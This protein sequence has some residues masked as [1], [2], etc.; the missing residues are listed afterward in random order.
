VTLKH[1]QCATPQEELAR[2]AAEFRRGLRA[3]FGDTLSA[4]DVEDIVQGALITRA[5]TVDDGRNAR[6]RK[7]WFTR[8]VHNLAIDYVR[9]RDGRNRAGRGPRQL[10]LDL[11]DQLYDGQAE[12]VIDALRV[13]EQGFD[14]DDLDRE[15]DTD[16]TRKLVRRAL[17]RLSREERRLIGLRFREGLSNA[18][19]ADTV[20]LTIKGLEKRWARTWV[21]FV[22]EAAGDAV[23]EERC[24]AMRHAAASQHVGI[25]TRDDAARW[26]AHLQECPACRVWHHVGS[27]ASAAIPAL[28]LGGGLLGKLGLVALVER[29]HAAGDQV[30]AAVGVGGGSAGA[31]VLSAIGGKAAATCITALVCA[32]GAA[33][34]A[35]PVV[36]RAVDPPKKE[37]RDEAA[38]KPHA[39]AAGASGAQRPTTTIT[40]APASV[41]PASQVAR[42]A[43]RTQASV[44]TAA[45]QRKTRESARIKREKAQAKQAR[46]TGSPFTP[47]A[48]DPTPAAVAASTSSS[49]AAAAPTPP[50]AA[51]DSSHFSGE[52]SP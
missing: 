31:G 7:A 36:R 4:E 12:S 6:Q 42:K 23:A 46:A 19:L 15:F 16:S 48:N 43:T 33:F 25:A 3:Q 30:A 45:A 50:P 49:T 20:G 24:L 17:G 22:N 44:Q 41:A 11:I 9:A 34:V 40:S 18:E 51:A 2:H 27:Q 1:G 26:E 35:A 13:N 47:E 14:V 10:S 8:V 21:A 39:K 52:F 38:S 5:P 29:V 28:P 37:H 32:G